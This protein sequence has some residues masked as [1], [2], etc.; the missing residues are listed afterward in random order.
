MRLTSLVWILAPA[1]LAGSMVAFAQGDRDRNGPPRRDRQAEPAADR[2]YPERSRGPEGNTWKAGQEREKEMRE[3]DRER[4][5]VWREYL[6]E[7][8]RAYKEWSKADRWEQDDF[9][10]Y[11]RDRRGGPGG[12]GN[13][14]GGN[15]PRDGVCFYTDAY[16]GGES[17][18]LDR[19]ERLSFVG[20]RYNDRISSIRVFGSARRITV[21]EHHYFEG[22]RRTIA[23]DIS[24]LGNFN[25]KISSIEVR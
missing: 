8:K 14:G 3:A 2:N 11:R 10:R 16:F 20:E 9:D 15:M 5:K 7:R 22:A 18:C 4:E 19:N 23:G 6:K 24:N 13:W 1:V 25:D 21:F 12:I 17:F